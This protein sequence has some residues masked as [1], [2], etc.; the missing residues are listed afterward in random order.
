MLLFTQIPI[1]AKVETMFKSLGDERQREH[2]PEDEPRSRGEWK[3]RL[4]YLPPIVMIP[5][6]IHVLNN[7]DLDSDSDFI[8]IAVFVVTIF[9]IMLAIGAFIFPKKKAAVLAAAADAAAA[10]ARQDRYKAQ[11]FR[12][13][14]RSESSQTA[15][16]H[17]E[18]ASKR[19]LG[20]VYV[21]FGGAALVL[22]SLV[23]VVGSWVGDYGRLIGRIG[24]IVCFPIGLM[25]LRHGQ[26]H[27][28]VDANKLLE[29][30]RR[31]PVLYL[32]AFDDDDVAA[33]RVGSRNLL[34]IQFG[35]EATEEQQIAEVAARV[36]P[37]VAIG[38]PADQQNML[39]AARMYLADDEWQ[40]RV[41][42]LMQR[43]A[44]V[45]LRAGPSEGFWWEVQRTLEII[46][47]ERLVILLPFGPETYAAFA[48]RINTLLPHALPGDSGPMNIKGGTLRGVVWFSEGWIPHLECRK[49]TKGNLILSTGAP[50][51][52][53]LDYMLIPVFHQVGARHAAMRNSTQ[54]RIWAALIDFVIVNVLMVVAW[55]FVPVLQ[56]LIP[57]LAT[58]SAT[59]SLVVFAAAFVYFGIGELTRSPGKLLLRLHVV[60][61]Q[62]ER[63]S[64]ARSLLRAFVKGAWVS[65][66]PIAIFGSWPFNILPMV[67]S[68]GLTLWALYSVGST[69]RRR[70]AHDYL[71]RCFVVHSINNPKSVQ[72]L[73][74]GQVTQV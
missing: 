21:I 8:P 47:P 43:S 66:I 70:F 52:S 53:F 44:L 68:V 73:S 28:A 36:G 14:M 41:L 61:N 18:V 16:Q 42:D 2:P 3:R 7:L 30:D 55:I 12:S 27:R 49:R 51:A 6:C 34:G 72:D 24:A 67:V 11:T 48:E 60:D 20:L 69:A 22:G 50:V 62:G 33:E 59:P 15:G 4:L 57:A 64:R 25:L 19:G 63:L 23:L 45:I 71:C 31:A 26:R 29:S 46:P 37:M 54:R 13:P 17:R 39:G 74:D 9:S 5:V 1:A 65:A 38:R 32:R 58:I 40:G 10:A 35:V 56:I